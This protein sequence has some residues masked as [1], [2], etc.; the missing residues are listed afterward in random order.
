MWV[1]KQSPNR[2][3]LSA[4][5]VIDNLEVDRLREKDAAKEEEKR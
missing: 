4:A 3:K 2:S 5:R 1:S